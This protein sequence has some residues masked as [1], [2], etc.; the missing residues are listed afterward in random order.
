MHNMLAKALKNLEC[1]MMSGNNDWLTRHPTIEK[2]LASEQVW[3]E[4]AEG[5]T[6]SEKDGS[7]A[8]LREPSRSWPR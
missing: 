8:Q 2:I 4:A 1:S 7:L 3:F 5:M 6:A